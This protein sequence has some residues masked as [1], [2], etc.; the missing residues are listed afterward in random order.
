MKAL[1]GR[2]PEGSLAPIWCC[3]A[4]SLG[5]SCP[6][7]DTCKWSV[8]AA[9]LECSGAAEPISWLWWC[10]VTGT[11]GQLSSKGLLFLSME[12]TVRAPHLLTPPECPLRSRCLCCY[13]C[14]GCQPHAWDPWVRFKGWQRCGCRHSP[15][16]GQAQ[17]HCSFLSSCSSR[18]H[19]SSLLGPR[20]VCTFPGTCWEAELWPHIGPDAA[21]WRQ[22]PWETGQAIQHWVP[23]SPSSLHQPAL[24][25]CSSPSL[26]F[27]A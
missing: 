27:V 8:L 10:M 11:P 17:H 2:D 15:C 16:E 3:K 12:S 6:P 21:C 5:L 24:G 7:M 22:P 9:L 23:D 14:L 1:V 25:L 26:L 13:P 20:L 18:V 4:K 19:Y